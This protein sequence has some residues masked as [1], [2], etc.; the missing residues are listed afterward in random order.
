MIVLRVWISAGKRFIT[1]LMQATHALIPYA[2]KTNFYSALN[3]EIVALRDPIWFTA[4][5][6]AAACLKQHLPDVNWAGFYLLREGELT[7]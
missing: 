4:L 2:D 3:A 5:A 7:L 6:N 1:S